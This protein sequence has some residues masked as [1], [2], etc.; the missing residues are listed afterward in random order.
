MEDHRLSSGY[1]HYLYLL[2]ILQL[3]FGTLYSYSAIRNK[4]K[5][6][7]MGKFIRKE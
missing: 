2:Q 7:E 5:R 4:F 1:T 6:E 3:T